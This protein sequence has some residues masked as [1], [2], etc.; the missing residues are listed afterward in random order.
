MNILKVYKE[1]EITNAEMIDMLQKLGFIEVKG[2]AHDYRMENK[3]FDMYLLMPRRPL[4]EFIWKGYTAKFSKMLLDF[5]V[6][7]DYDDLVKMVLK[8][9]LKKQAAVEQPL[10]S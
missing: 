10:S 7:E 3:A 2:D 6:I 5:G 4:N 9:R 8:E 1:T